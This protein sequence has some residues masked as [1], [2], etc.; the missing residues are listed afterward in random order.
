MAQESLYGKGPERKGRACR[1]KIF[2]EEKA[3]RAKVLG[4]VRAYISKDFKESGKEEKMK[5][6]ELSHK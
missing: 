5:W 2:W 3:A 1:R 4:Q 6:S